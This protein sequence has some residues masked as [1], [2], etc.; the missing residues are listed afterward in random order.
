MGK[1]CLDCTGLGYGQVAGAC[2]CCNGPSVSIKSG[3]F[4]TSWGSLSYPGR[5]VLHV[6]IYLLI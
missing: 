1:H 5:N 6:V 4:L 2:E 3:S